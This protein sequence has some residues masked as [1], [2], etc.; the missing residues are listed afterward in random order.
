MEGEILD[1]ETPTTAAQE[2][3]RAR[4]DQLLETYDPQKANE[5][6][7]LFRDR[8]TWVEPTLLVN[9][10]PRCA[11]SPLPPLDADS[12]ADLPGFLHRFVQQPEIEPEALDRDCRRAA[13]L[14]EIVGQLERSGVRLL[15]GSDAPNPGVRP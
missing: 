14:T 15:A 4:T 11:G 5:L 7:T 9:A 3:E 1:S 10:D 8:G 12:L 6:F 2:A 13:K